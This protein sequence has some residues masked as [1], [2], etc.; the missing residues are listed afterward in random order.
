MNDSLRTQIT[1][2]LGR[3]LAKERFCLGDMADALIKELG[4]TKVWTDV[5]DKP[6]TRYVTGWQPDER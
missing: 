1:K 5:P 6:Y 2:I 4:L 3:H